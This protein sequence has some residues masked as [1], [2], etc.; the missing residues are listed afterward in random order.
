MK[1]RYNSSSF[2][3]S[4]LLFCIV[5]IAI[6]A[7]SEKFRHDQVKL[8]VV[9]EK[10]ITL[11]PKR[12]VITIDIL[13]TPSS[14]YNTQ[15]NDIR[16]V[17]KHDNRYMRLEHIPEMIAWYPA[18][19]GIEKKEKPLLVLRIDNKTPMGAVQ[20]VFTILRQRDNLEVFLLM[21]QKPTHQPLS[22]R[23]MPSNR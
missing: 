3:L 2:V 4:L 8:P 9:S 5:T 14:R 20:D 17:M 18:C 11:P 6:L 16:Y 23:S 13:P 1:D 10:L 19:Q 22:Y 15:C 21:R 12:K 7:L